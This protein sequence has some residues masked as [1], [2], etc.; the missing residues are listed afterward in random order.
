MTGRG[1]PYKCSYCATATLQKIYENKGTF[2]RF[3]SPEN[4]ID[5]ILYVKK[6][7]GLK[8][9]CF[10][11]D[12]FILKPSRLVKLLELYGKKVNL[13][14]IC[15]I[16]AD[17]VTEEIVKILKENGCH[18][19]DFGVESGNENI[20][21]NLL[22]KTVTNEQIKFAAHLLR[23]YKIPFRTTNM[24]GLPLETIENAFETVQLNQIIKTNFPSCSIYQP[25]PRTKLGDKAIELKLT[26]PDYSVDK[27]ASTFYLYS[28]LPTK[29]YKK[30]INLQKFFF[31]AV[32]FPSLFPL[33]KK[34][35]NLPPN[36]LFNYIFLACYAYNYMKSENISLSRVISLGMHTI[37]TFFFGKD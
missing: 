19:V 31:L 9:V 14:F 36:K 17:L 23:K 30:F 22:E 13:P 15:H 7:Y 37:K 8:T 35:I 1:C 11:D 34:L 2:T 10:Q 16:R 4:V 29:D 28:V 18:S 20:R 24:L 5:E 25:Y 21:K 27:I 12:T 32:K 3:R 26:P 6:K 33:I